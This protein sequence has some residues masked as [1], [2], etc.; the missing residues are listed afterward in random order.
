MKNLKIKNL[1]VE[2]GDQVILNDLSLEIN[3]GDTLALLGPNGHGK[4]TLLNSIMGSSDYKVT[5]GDIL[6]DNQ[7]ILNL[8]VDQ[9]SK[10]GIFMAFQNPPEI[11]GVLTM[12][13]LKSS[14]NAHSASPI[15]IYNFYKQV[16]DAYKKVN[17][18]EN[19]I[20]RNLNDGFSGGEKK[21]NEI[22]QMLLL[23]PTLCMLDEIDSGLDVDSI[24]LIS[25]IILELKKQ[26][27]TFIIISHYQKLLE[28]IK[29]NKTAVLVNGKIVLN[30]DYSLSEKVATQGYNFLK[31]E[32]GIDIKKKEKATVMLETCAVKR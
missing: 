1:K 32:Y 10:L 22:L 24:K 15:S 6:L 16:S 13:F 28:L 2:T 14:I 8:T 29:P 12:D 23:K 3:S 21:R 18:D 25:D 31:K 11:Q 9:R 20:N 26:G 30:G 17:L 7:S 27:T 5:S 4:S 19:L